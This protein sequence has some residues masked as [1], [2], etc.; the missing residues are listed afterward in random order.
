MR[1][2]RV[3]FTVRWIMTAVAVAAL[4]SLVASNPYR[5]DEITDKRAVIPIASVIAAVYG[6]GS[7][8]RPLT[9]LLPL[10][11]MWIATPQVDHPTPDVVNVSAVGCFVGWLVGAPAGWVCRRRTRL[12]YPPSLKGA[13]GDRAKGTSEL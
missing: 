1:L 4:V 7:M 5:H 13:A 12:H 3:R 10:L 6:L 9:F 11:A 2:P 8:Q